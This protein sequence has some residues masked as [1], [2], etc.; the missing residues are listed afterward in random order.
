MVGFSSTQSGIY[1]AKRKLRET[2]CCVVIYALMSNGWLSS[3]ICFMHNVECF[4][5]F[6]GVCREQCIYS[7]FIWTWKS[8]SL[9]DGEAGAVELWDTPWRSLPMWG[10]LFLTYNIGQD[11]QGRVTDNGNGGHPCLVHNPD[12][13]M[14][15]FSVV[16]MILLV[17]GY[18]NS[19]PKN[20]LLCLLRQRRKNYI[21]SISVLIFIPFFIDFLGVYS[22]CLPNYLE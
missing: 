18:L 17:R 6:V 1:E 8:H 22:F 19:L 20:E 4:L 21:V 10:L 9:W 5:Y 12:R 13:N 11:L 3:H 15:F 16:S 14:S 7:I 2:H